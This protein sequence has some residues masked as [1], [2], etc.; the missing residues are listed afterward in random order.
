MTDSDE[1]T[2]NFYAALA[3]AQPRLQELAARNVS[4]Q[5]AG[6]TLARLEQGLSETEKAAFA[7]EFV[8]SVEAARA[9]MPEDRSLPLPDEHYIGQ[10]VAMGNT[11]ADAEAM[12]A[13]GKDARLH[14]GP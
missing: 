10:L 11:R 4:P 7:Q 5:V 6:E 12:F 1:P 9:A 14:G 3:Q 8:A 13:L 2:P